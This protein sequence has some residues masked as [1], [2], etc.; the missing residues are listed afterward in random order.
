[1][2]DTRRSPFRALA[3]SVSLLALSA[4]SDGLDLDLRSVAGGLDTTEAARQPTESRPSPDSLGIISYPSF[5][6]AVARR[7]DTVQAVAD[8]IGQDAAT[9]A[10]YNGLETGTRLRR[11]EVL[12][13]PTRV[14]AAPGA[15]GATEEIDI[16]ALAGNALDRAGQSQTA[17]PTPVVQSGPEPIQH[18]VVRG[19]TAFSIA[20]LYNV[21]V[22][23]LADWN[24]LGPD[25]NVREGQFLLIP[26]ARLPERTAEVPQAE[27]NEDT[28]AIPGEGSVA[29]E[30]PSASSP[31]PEPEEEPEITVED[32]PAPNLGDERTSASATKFAMPVQ[33]PIVRDFQK[34]VNDGI[35][36]SAS[37][38]TSVKAAG[39]GTVASI[40][41]SVDGSE[42][43]VIRHPGDLLTV[44]VN[45][46]DL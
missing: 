24:G 35:D 26:I 11:G 29:P 20:R 44:Y 37:G 5:D 33:G 15:P 45:V 28:V 31:L 40:L 41:G 4:C 7:G 42:V 22:R 1:M 6:V 21:S 46:G 32:N 17:R 27:E 14:A 2:A 43:L 3:V 16:T 23:S 10:R 12:A 18:Q 30:P 13:L 39:N 9:L 8:R 36:I 19:E 25:L 38:G 34:D